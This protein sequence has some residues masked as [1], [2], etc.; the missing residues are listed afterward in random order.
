MPFHTRSHATLHTLDLFP[1]IHKFVSI[2]SNV[3]K[4]QKVYFVS[5][6]LFLGVLSSPCFTYMGMQVLTRDLSCFSEIFYDLIYL[7]ATK[8]DAT[9]H[10]YYYS[11]LPGTHHW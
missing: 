7:L 3:L 11:F 9:V 6:G 5:N 1:G 8:T 4:L 2:K 10:S